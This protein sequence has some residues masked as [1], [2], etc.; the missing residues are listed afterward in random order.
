MS[1]YVKERLLRIPRRGLIGREIHSRFPLQGGVPL[2]DT[3]ASLTPRLMA[4]LSSNSTNTLLLHY[5]MRIIKCVTCE[6]TKVRVK[7]APGSKLK[8]LV[9]YTYQTLNQ[10]RK[11][12]DHCS[13]SRSSYL[14][15]PLSCVA[16][17]FF[18][19]PRR[20][21]RLRSGTVLCLPQACLFVKK[22]EEEE[23]E[24]KGKLSIGY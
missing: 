3:M 2:F 16:F 18:L 24:V 17:L 10:S 20:Q 1:G 9:Y 8:S 14:Q 13:T 22:N 15:H 7:L 6:T 12:L 19:R 23:E 21:A 11:A 5:K 4:L